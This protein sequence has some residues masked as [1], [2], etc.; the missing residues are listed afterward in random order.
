MG[1]D[2]IR[3]NAVLS[4]ACQKRTIH[5]KGAL[6][7]CILIVLEENKMQSSRTRKMVILAVLSA[8]AYVLMLYWRIPVLTVP[9]YLKYDPKD[10]I[11]TISGF[12]FGP[13]PVVMMSLVVSFL[14]MITAS[15]TGIIGFLMNVVS[16]CAFACTA[17]FIYK[18]VHSLKGAI[19][20]LVVGWIAMAGVMLLWNY[21]VTP[22][23]I[24]SLAVG[25]SDLEALSLA[26][27]EIRPGVVDMLIPVF[28]PFNLLKGGLNAAITMLVYKP[29]R[30][31]L[32]KSRLLPEE[33]G[34]AQPSKI[35][36]GAM[37]VSLFLL[38][39]GIMLILVYQG[40]I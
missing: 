3:L 17:A 16:T 7:R 30:A 19:I 10:V 33:T 1:E 25:F 12:I 37:L 32:S 18:K 2:E 28:L 5:L 9:P 14:E 34:A 26:A 13:L 39:T 11:F 15:D 23:Y 4:R 38:L 27:G 6:F 36:L 29:I 31:G 35:N 21:I 8:L 40:A 24:A 22:I 20:G